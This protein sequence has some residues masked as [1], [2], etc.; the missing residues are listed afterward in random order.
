MFFQWLTVVYCLIWAYSVY[1]LGHWGSF[2]LML[3][4]ILFGHRQK[5][6]KCFFRITDLKGL[7]GVWFWSRWR[8]TFLLMLDFD[9]RVFSKIWKKTDFLEF[10]GYYP[11]KDIWSNGGQMSQL[12]KP[13]ILCLSNIV[14]FLRTIPY[15][16]HLTILGAICVYWFFIAF[17]YF[18]FPSRKD[19]LSAC[20]QMM[21]VELVWHW[22]GGADF[23]QKW[24]FLAISSGGGGRQKFFE[25]PDSGGGMIPWFNQACGLVCYFIAKFP[26]NYELWDGN[27]NFL[28]W[29]G[30]RNM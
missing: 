2:R 17:S 19:E 15:L 13:I 27:F 9:H 16:A 23:D 24:P 4:Y 25:D 18:S 12:Q 1:F 26:G 6:F 20:A 22:G 8:G 28:D 29:K 14:F 21:D 30:L 5:W 10:I 7:P 11:I 3:L